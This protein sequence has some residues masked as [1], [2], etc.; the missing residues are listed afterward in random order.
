MTAPEAFAAPSAGDK[1]KQRRNA[2][3]QAVVAIAVLLIVFGVILPEVIDY[4]QVGQILRET[5]AE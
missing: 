5:E 1:A 3:I 4:Q 2:L